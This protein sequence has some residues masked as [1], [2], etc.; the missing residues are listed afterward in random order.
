METDHRIFF[1]DSREMGA[2]SSESIDLVVTSP[3]YPMIAMWDETFSLI[4]PAVKTALSQEDGM[5]AFYLMHRELDRVWDEAGRVLKQGGLAC[6][7]IGDA[8]RTLGTDFRLYPNHSR[9]L[10]KFLDLNFNVLPAIIWRK[11]TNAP[12][13]FMGSGMLPAVAYVTLEHEYI[14]ILRK[15]P[16]RKFKSE[17]EKRVRRESAIFWEERNAWY[18]DVWMD[19]K[20]T[21]QNMNHEQ[22]RSRS[23]AFPF[24]LAYRL[25]NMHSVK[26]DV[27][28]DPFLG[29]A[30]TMAAAMASGRNS[31]GFEI[32]PNFREAVHL[33]MRT[34]KDP[35]N[36]YVSRRLDNH[37]D[38]VRTRTGN[39]GLFKHQNKHYGFPVITKQETELVLSHLASISQ[40]GNC[41]RVTYSANPQDKYISHDQKAYG[42]TS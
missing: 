16:A 10:S 7:N 15:G 27:V 22:T 39:G 32:D 8:T 5:R 12:N 31:I 13:K 42:F 25:I 9:I 20:G 18:S 38:F 37:Q 34:V 35:A 6:I 40:T 4:N 11:Q 21:T 36:E 29:T 24:E 3:P 33:K 1:A 17:A 14:L 26:E 28:L 19:L 41:F 2:V 30:T 23:G